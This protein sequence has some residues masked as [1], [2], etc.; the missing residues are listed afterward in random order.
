MC[1]SKFNDNFHLSQKNQIQRPDILTL[2]PKKQHK[3]GHL[4]T[5]LNF[6]S[7]PSAKFANSSYAIEPRSYFPRC[8]WGDKVRY[9]GACKVRRCEFRRFRGG[10]VLPRLSPRLIYTCRKA[11][12][13]P[14]LGIGLSAAKR[15]R[16]TKLLALQVNGRVSKTNTRSQEG[17]IR[18]RH[19]RNNLPKRS[20][21]FNYKPRVFVILGEGNCVTF[22]SHLRNNFFG[23]EF[24]SGAWECFF[25]C[26]LF[27]G[28]HLLHTRKK[29]L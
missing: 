9:Q 17:I 3:F 27:R 18:P 5:P 22:S 4:H 10:Q 29:I 21:K 26:A 1:T 19:R 11:R 23:M 13:S 20:Q 12:I 28:V 7:S 15:D 24:Y 8:N 25:Y 14:Y 6:A 16:A 2:G